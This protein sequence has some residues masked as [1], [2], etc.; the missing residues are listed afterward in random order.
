MNNIMIALI[1]L[2]GAYLLFIGLVTN[3]RN[4]SSALIFK[5]FP[6]VFGLCS[7]FAGLYFAGFVVKIP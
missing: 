3:T 7:L 2:S 4:F 1:L 6:V 5:V